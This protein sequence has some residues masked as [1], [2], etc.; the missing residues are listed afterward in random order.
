[1]WMGHTDSRMLLRLPQTLLIVIEATK[2]IFKCPASTIT[3]SFNIENKL[4]T[5]KYKYYKIHIMNTSST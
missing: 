5:L 3:I 2:I 1:M 4:N